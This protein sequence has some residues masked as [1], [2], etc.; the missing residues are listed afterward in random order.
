MSLLQR[1]CRLSF[2]VATA[3]VACL[4]VAAARA[5]VVLPAGRTT[6]NVAFT[7]S[8]PDGTKK[9][10]GTFCR[11]GPEGASH[12]MYLSP[13]SFNTTLVCIPVGDR[14]EVSI[15]PGITGGLSRFSRR[16]N[17]TVPFPNPP[18][19]PPRAP[20][21]SA[22]ERRP[23]VAATQTVVRAIAEAARQNHRSRRP[24]TG[25]RLTE[26][27]VRRA[28]AVAQRLPPQV[29]AEA[30]LIGLGMGLDESIVLRANPLTGRLCR[31]VESDRQRAARLDSLGKPTVRG[32][33]DLTQHF[34]VSAALTA[35]LG[36]QSAEAAGLLKELNDSHR[37]S[38][39][40]F[41]DLAADIAGVS[42]AVRV[43]QRKIS[44]SSLATSFAV[45]DFMPPTA[46][47]EEGINWKAF[48]AVYGSA[49]N[50][51]FRL[52]KEEIRRQILALPGFEQR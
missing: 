17:G 14:V 50:E 44:L 37:G 51:R 10:T 28:A 7:M 9:G 49:D 33:D 3:V 11:N 40:S 41:A 42:F 45:R 43:R 46:A 36:Q 18:D 8:W 31:Q 26:F 30:F 52:K 32:R 19:K 25:D 23:L 1:F 12:K 38:G 15:N 34:F 5:G 29:A 16:E 24:L 22:G 6:A 20:A 47:F 2:V 27:Y 21:E 39:F 4:F 35:V 48:S 13:F